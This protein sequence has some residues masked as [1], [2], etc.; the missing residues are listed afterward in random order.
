M[1]ILEVRSL[2]IPELV[3]VRF[4][5]F[6]DDRGYFG[7]TFRRSAAASDPDAAFLAALDFPQ[8]NESYSRAGTIRGLHFQWNP[9]MGKLV[10]T[11]SG[12][13]VDLALD[14]RLGSPTLGKIVAYDLPAPPDA[15][16]T[17]W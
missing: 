3:V 5:R 12:R 15:P 8:L 17:E 13:M 6:H 2:A 10:R 9:F 14:I 1:R 16:W 7:E 11:V 4:G